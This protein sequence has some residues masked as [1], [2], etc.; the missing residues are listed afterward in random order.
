MTQ[1]NGRNERARERQAQW[2]TQSYLGGRLRR[3]LEVDQDASIPDDFMALL[4]RADRAAN[5]QNKS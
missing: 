5:D 1:K 4:K 2:E 3:E